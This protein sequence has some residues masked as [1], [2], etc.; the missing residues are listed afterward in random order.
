MVGSRTGLQPPGLREQVL[1]AGADNQVVQD[2]D[3]EEPKGFGQPLGNELVGLAGLGGGGGTIVIENDGGGVAL[4]HNAGD[5]ARVHGGAVDRAAEENLGANQAMTR[6]EEQDA[7]DLVRQRTV[8]VAE[9]LAGAHGVAEA[10]TAKLTRR[11]PEASG[12]DAGLKCVGARAL[13]FGRP[14]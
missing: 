10:A 6:V 14:L 5:L 4:D 11:L 1:G 8:L 13:D 7:E 2:V 12:P 3:V 9:V